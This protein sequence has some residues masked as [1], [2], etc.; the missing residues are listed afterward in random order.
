MVGGITFDSGALKTGTGGGRGGV[1]GGAFSLSVVDSWLAVA[2][3]SGFGAAS[4]SALVA[5][6]VCAGG[7]GNSWI[8]CARQT[9]GYCK[10]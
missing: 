5:A 3:V 6:L 8:I 4:A 7:L 2:V 10:L 9:C 1:V